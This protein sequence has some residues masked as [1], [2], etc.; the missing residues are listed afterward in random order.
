MQKGGYMKG[1]FQQNQNQDVPISLEDAKRLKKEIDDLILK[2]N[3]LQKE[4]DTAITAA[5][6]DL[7]DEYEIKKQRL[8]AEHNQKIAV[9]E[10]KMDDVKKDAAQNQQ[11]R[12]A[13]NQLKI[14][15]DDRAATLTEKE[16]FAAN[17]KDEAIKLQQNTENEYK[18]RM[19]DVDIK[20]NNNVAIQNSLDKRS[21]ELDDREFQLDEREK[22]LIDREGVARTLKDQSTA[23]IAEYQQKKDEA[24][25]ELKKVNEM[26]SSAE[27]LKKSLGEKIALIAEKEA[28]VD[29]NLN[30]ATELEKNNN[31]EKTHLSEWNKNLTEREKSVGERERLL[32]LH[33]RELDEKIK[34]LEELRTK[35]GV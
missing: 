8:L 23:L 19:E 31:T 5:L 34:R 17:L 3:N 4:I 6:K 2:R 25:V 13:L 12:I 27:V 29:A 28:K 10:L 26:L 24:L 1:G 20:A 16:N 9:L 15:L 21:S 22:R 7:R 33:N 35:G 30:T 14:S 18:E 11:D 32:V